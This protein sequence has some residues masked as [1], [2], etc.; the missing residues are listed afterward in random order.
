MKTVLITGAA[1]GIG[2]ST[3]ILFSK[4]GWNVAATMRSLDKSDEFK[5]YKNVNCYCIDVTNYKS[6][7]QCI[8]RIIQEFGK[9]DALVNNAG[10]YD[11]EP[12]E[13]TSYETIDKLIKTNVNGYLYT[14]KAILPHFRKNKEGVILNVSS[15]AGRVTFPYQ[16]VYH[17]SKW[18]IEGMSEGLK[19]ELDPLNIK[20][21]IVE[22]GM[23]K[24]NLYNSITDNSFDKYPVDYAN[25]Y[26]KWHKYLIGNYKKGYYPYLDA[27][28]IYKAVNDNKNKLRYVTDLNTKLVFF[29]RAIFSLSAFQNIVNKQIN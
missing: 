23:V 13:L 28:T 12:L 22:P 6:I 15:I 11:T 18:A 8:E 9:I 25:R 29:L 7:E 1:S 26:K 5:E 14:I 19:Y 21:K 16:S 20:V 4:N 27:T 10:I 24:T 2:R 3:A 17:A